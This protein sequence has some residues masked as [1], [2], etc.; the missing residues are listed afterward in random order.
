[1]SYYTA[2]T[3]SNFDDR[4]YLAALERDT[5]IDAA[6]VYAGNYEGLCD[7]HSEPVESVNGNFINLSNGATLGISH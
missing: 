6:P 2:R 4:E 7:T 1:M 3:D 5:G